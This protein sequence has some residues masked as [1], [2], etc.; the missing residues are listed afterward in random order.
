M[1]MIKYEDTS[2][3]IL[4]EAIKSNV[5]AP[6]Y[7]ATIDLN[8]TE[9]NCQIPM[10]W[11]R[12][13]E[14]IIPKIN[15]TE[16]WIEGKLYFV[17]P[18]QFLIVN[19]KEVHRCRGKVVNQKYYGYALQINYE[20]LQTLFDDIDAFYFDTIYINENEILNILNQI[21]DIYFSNDS[22]KNI[23]MMG[24]IYELMYVLLSNHCHLKSEGYFIQSEKQKNRLVKIL[25]YIDDEC[26]HITDVKSIAEHFHL[27]YGYVANLFKTYLHITIHDA[28]SQARIKHIENELITTD[29]SIT[30]IYTAHGFTNTKSFY[31]EFS[32]Y[33]DMTPHA[34]RKNARNQSNMRNS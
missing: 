21:I 5:K 18:N 31:R 9:E 32:K 2:N 16:T 24:L 8:G 11:H 14:F 6:I 17:D 27:S 22:L 26:D 12:S 34:Y 13:L 3:E 33:H 19:S 30:E 29:K 1:Q 28:L 25:T 7:V 23:Q 10:H 4:Y 15:S 20:F